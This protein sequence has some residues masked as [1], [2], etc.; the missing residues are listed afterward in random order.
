LYLWLFSAKI[1]RLWKFLQ[2]LL[3]ALALSHHKEKKWKDGIFM[4]QFF[5]KVREVVEPFVDTM[6]R[7]DE[8]K[9]LTVLVYIGKEDTP[10]KELQPVWVGAFGAATNE[11]R[12]V[13]MSKAEASWKTGCDSRNLSEGTW[14][15]NEKTVF[16]WPGALCFTDR[17]TDT[18]T[19]VA[20]SGLTGRHDETLARVVFEV[21]NTISDDMAQVAIKNNGIYTIV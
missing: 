16:V 9:G 17:R 12:D 6:L 15:L 20:V 4:G 13:A 18:R 14:F 5:I 1:P 19:V 8:R 21:I 10:F 7:L 2:I 3:L 11:S